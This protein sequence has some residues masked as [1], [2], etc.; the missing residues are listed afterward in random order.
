[1]AMDYMEG[2]PVESLGAE[3]PQAV[4]DAL[5]AALQRLMF[6]ELFE[7]RV[8]QT[9]PNFANYLYQPAT[10]RLVLLDF[11][12]TQQFSRAYTERYRRITRA[13]VAGDRPAIEREARRIGYIADDASQEVVDAA[14]EVL[15]LVSEPLRYEDVYDYGASDLPRRARELGVD[16]AFKRGLLRMPP[17]HTLFLHRKLVGVYLLL[18]RL[19]AHVP[20]GR[21]LRPFLA[22][23]GTDDSG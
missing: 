4:R 22:P 1:M 6:R 23:R 5:G 3:T 2:V 9:D 19:G 12:A 21:L 20:T 14:M 11:G 15:E 17:S 8:M 18:A 13:I 10:A 7:F 16:L